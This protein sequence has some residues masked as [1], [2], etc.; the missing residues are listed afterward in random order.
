[1][2]QND[3]AIPVLPARD[4]DETIA[5]WLKLGF[6]PVMRYPEEGYAI[7]RSGA[8]EVHLF[9]WPELDPS[10]NFSS[11]YL[12]VADADVLYQRFVKAELP[13]RGIPSLG[14]IERKF[15]N[16]REF[17]LVDPNGNLVRV[18]EQTARPARPPQR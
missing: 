15:Y 2:A 5:F 11:C 16:M 18:G 9:R 17:R 1:M 10:T 4:L 14:G 8:F 6:E 3:V 13:A 12:R 7:L